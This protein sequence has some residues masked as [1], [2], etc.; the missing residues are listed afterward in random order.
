MK[1]FGCI[2]DIKYIAKINYHCFVLLSVEAARKYKI[3]YVKL[4]VFV[5]DRIAV[6]ILFV[7]NLCLCFLRVCTQNKDLDLAPTT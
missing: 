3:T 2:S 5:Q 7:Y 1:C 6:N 4:I